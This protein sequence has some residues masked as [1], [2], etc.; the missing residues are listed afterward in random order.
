MKN[1]GWKPALRNGH[2]QW[3]RAEARSQK[4]NAPTEVGAQFSMKQLYQT[5]YALV[6]EK[7]G[8]NSYF[9]KPLKGKEIMKQGDRRRGVTRPKKT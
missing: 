4:Q 8:K 2:E 3:G 1:A 5:R 7:V 6:K 9:C